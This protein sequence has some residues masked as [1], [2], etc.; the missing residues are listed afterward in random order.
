M[1]AHPPLRIAV[2]A[3][4]VAAFTLPA[5]ESTNPFAG[6][7]DQS[8]LLTLVQGLSGPTP[9]QTARQVFDRED[10]DVRRRAIAMLSAAEWGGESEYLA[11]YRLIL[12]DPD[13]TVRA[14]CAAALG[15]HGEPGDA[16]LVGNQ[17][18][19]EEAFLRWEAAK[20]LRRLHNPVAVPR[21]IETLQ[22]DE[23][24]DARMAAAEAL[25]QYHRREV[26]DALVSALTEPEYGIAHA[27]RGS[28]HTLTGHDAGSEPRDWR[29]FAAENPSDLFANARPYTYRGYIAPPGLLQRTWQKAAFWEEP[30]S[31]EQTP[32]GMES[33]SPS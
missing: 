6:P 16:L 20:A 11:V 18:D 19:A 25:G 28:L 21:L 12:T 8:V 31:N 10:P 1:S 14:A 24:P 5:C 7:D 2:A 15:R 9:S 17:L 26:F 30:E 32:E 4:V 33:D 13:P 23:D 3:V 27:A 29:T 22:T